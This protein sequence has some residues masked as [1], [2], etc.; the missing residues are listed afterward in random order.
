MSDARQ[1]NKPSWYGLFPEL[2]GVIANYLND[3]TLGKLALT[4]YAHATSSEL[5]DNLLQAR[6]ENLIDNQIWCGQSVNKPKN[7]VIKELIN[8]NGKVIQSV[9]SLTC[10][11]VY[12]TYQFYLDT[13]GAVWV[14]TRRG[15][16]KPV[17]GLRNIYTMFNVRNGLPFFVDYAMKM[18]VFS[19]TEHME[20][21]R[22][23]NNFDVSGWPISEVKS[24]SK[25]KFL[26]A[27]P[28]YTFIVD[29]NGYVWA[30]GDNFQGGL[31]LQ[32]LDLYSHPTKIEQLENIERVYSNGRST[33]FVSQDNIVFAC[34][35]NESWQLGG[36]VKKSLQVEPVPVATLDEKIKTILI[37]NNGSC[38]VSENGEMYAA[39]TNFGWCYNYHAFREKR[40]EELIKKQNKILKE[41]QVTLAKLLFL[42]KQ[43]AFFQRGQQS[44]FAIIRYLK[45]C[46]ISERLFYLFELDNSA[47]RNDYQYTLLFKQDDYPINASNCEHGLSWFLCRKLNIAKALIKVYENLQEDKYKHFTDFLIKMGS[48][49]FNTVQDLQVFLDV[50]LSDE[51]IFAVPYHRD[52]NDLCT[53][54]YWDN[55]LFLYL[56]QLTVFFIKAINSTV[57]TDEK[58]LYLRETFKQIFK[59]ETNETLP[60]PTR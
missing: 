31:G 20:L 30:C 54:L 1:P 29:E 27:Q 10:T 22:R 36:M 6:L 34:G 57:Y 16:I 46:H 23:F 45:S 4:S 42:A 49:E 26:L 19:E 33:L 17:P 7:T 14:K 59:G 32:N 43:P 44:Y 2:Q 56:H 18:F 52:M 51:N 47:W 12:C 53:L 48:G 40:L 38:L 15:K 55:Y 5:V 8:E 11:F 9:A 25:V 3:K 41:Y 35:H 58:I 28:N 50:T 37:A 60:S 21:H 24:I 13:N 39:G